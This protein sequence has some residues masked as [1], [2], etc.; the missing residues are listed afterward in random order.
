MLMRELPHGCHLIELV[1]YLWVV[2]LIDSVHTLSQCCTCRRCLAWDFCVEVMTNTCVRQT[3]CEGQNLSC[4]I[5]PWLPPVLL[6]KGWT[7]NCF[8]LCSPI[9]FIPLFL[10]VQHTYLSLFFP[11]MSSRPG[12][13][14]FV[15]QSPEFSYFL[16]FC[17]IATRSSNT[18][19]RKITRSQAANSGRPGM[20]NPK[21]KPKQTCTKATQPSLS[22]A[23]SVPQKKKKEAQQQVEAAHLQSRSIFLYHGHQQKGTWT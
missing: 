23:S 3:E 12:I 9:P 15:C 14:F 17:R 4:S 1:A 2:Y 19:T 10:I 11:T 5:L 21:A 7:C 6:Y 8:S 16:S 13:V 22:P 20:V 18:S